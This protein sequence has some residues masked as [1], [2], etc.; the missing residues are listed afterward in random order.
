MGQSILEG[1]SWSTDAAATSYEVQVSTVSGFGSTLLDQIG[2]S[3]KAVLQNLTPSTVYYWHAQ[4]SSTAG[5]SGWSTTWS[6]TTAHYFYDTT[7]GST[8]SVA[9]PLSANPTLN[10]VPLSPYDE[11][12]VFSKAGL[13][14]GSDIWDSV[15]GQTLVIVGQNTLLTD[16]GIN[17]DGLNEGDS[18]YFRV[19]DHSSR[20]EGLA[21]VTFSSGGPVYSTNG[22]GEISSLVAT[23]IPDVPVLS[24]PANGLTGQATALT[25]AWKTDPG[26]L[27]F[28]VQVST[29]SAFSSTVLNQS[30]ITSLTKAVGSLANLLTY[31]WKVNAT[32]ALGTTAWSGAWSFTTT[33]AGVPAVPALSLP[34]NGAT[35]QS[36]SPTVSWSTVSG[37]TSYALQVASV[38][39]F[40]T[41][42]AGQSG[43]TATTFAVKGLSNNLTYYWRA[44]A[45]SGSG[46]SA[47]SGAWSFSTG[48][49]LVIPLIAGWNMMSLNIHPTDSTT[50]AVFG[51]LKGFILVNDGKGNIYVP[52]FGIDQIGTLTTG[53]GYQV[54]ADSTD[55]V[56]ATGSPVATASVA[57]TL[58]SLVWSIIAYLPQANM[59]I[60]TALAGITSKIIIVSDNA[61]DVYWP[62]PG[63]NSIDTM[64]VGQGYYI[65]TSAGASLTYPATGKMLASGAPMVSL[66]APRHFAKH[67]I[68]GN[69][70]F[71]L[72]RQVAVGGRPAPDNSEIGVFDAL[73]NLV[74]SGTVEHGMAA[75]AV[76]GKDRMTKVKDG[77]TPGEAISFRLWD[78]HA[79]YPAEAAGGAEQAFGVN[80]IIT[81]ALAASTPECIASFDLP[82]ITPNPFRGSVRITFVIP[83]LRGVADQPVEI[84]IY[85]M[86]GSLV[87]NLARGRFAAGNY[88]VTWNGRPSSGR[89]AGSGVYFLRMKAP[90]FD[91][92]VKIIE[93]K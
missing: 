93:L 57:V 53:L 10:G 60:A 34:A 39:T 81:A 79:E 9:L 92:Q 3:A 78:G 77:C 35:G 37:A 43:I 90:G 68:T 66:P 65:V 27:T 19:W 63:I 76:W 4:G 1:L 51:V 74:G 22:I 73:G 5:S 44:N 23:A 80:K 8:M 85:D 11:V 42:V 18:M 13:C 32:N 87:Q 61:G 28:A 71:I 29:A 56:R 41:T 26:T 84:G 25:L 45:T 33:A 49:G 91:R 30:G 46:T 86:K 75:F 89:E 31:Y 62:G 82:R 55:T 20:K 47:W 64:R 52:S 72:S 7:T 24:A 48:T 50:G 67:R 70:A 38:S 88:S 69:S 54:Y 40:A 17:I 6:F 21:A 16:T 36:T 14:V 58:D 83:A 12:G 59:P 15:T 2:P